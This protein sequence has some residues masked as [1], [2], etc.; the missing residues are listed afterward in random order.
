MICLASGAMKLKWGWG[1]GV[2]WDGGGAPWLWEGCVRTVSRLDH[3]GFTEWHPSTHQMEGRCGDQHQVCWAR[4][5][6]GEGASLWPKA[7]SPRAAC[8]EHPQKAIGSH[9]RFRVSQ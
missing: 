1:G 3:T 5:L 7:L 9:E 2:P 8:F 4:M 6:M